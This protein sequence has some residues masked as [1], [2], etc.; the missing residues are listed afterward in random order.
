MTYTGVGRW[1]VLV[2][3]SNEASSGADGSE[4]QNDSDSLYIERN[5]PK[6]LVKIPT[7]FQK[8]V[9]RT[10]SYIMILLTAFM[11]KSFL[12]GAKLQTCETK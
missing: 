10:F 6:Y 8:I 7:H 1:N 12:S 4:G 11:L 9:S 5:V 2:G 3:G